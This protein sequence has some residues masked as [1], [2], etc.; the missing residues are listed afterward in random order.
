M[1]RTH[2]DVLGVRPDAGV[3]EIRAAYLRLARRH[4]PDHQGGSDEAMQAVNGAWHVLGDARRRRAYDIEIGMADSRDVFIEDH[5]FDHDE[6]DQWVDDS[7]ITTAGQRGPLLTVAP[8]LLVVLAV[9]IFSV[10]LVLDSLAIIAMAG[11]AVMV[12]AVLFVLVP[13]TALGE[14]RRDEGK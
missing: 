12:A 8:P 1:A 7:P 5:P 10:G 13:L 6:P 3:E 11:V 14:A 2:Y 9:A 4:H